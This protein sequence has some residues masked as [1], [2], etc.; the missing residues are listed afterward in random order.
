MAEERS[1]RLKWA[2]EPAR[3]HSRELTPSGQKIGFL[4]ADSRALSREIEITLGS[5][6]FG[7]R[8]GSFV[9]KSHY[10]NAIIPKY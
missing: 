7:D 8:E 6:R 9:I 5:G 10:I 2:I 1:E 3:Q 4:N